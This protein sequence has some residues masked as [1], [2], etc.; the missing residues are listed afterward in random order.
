MKCENNTLLWL[1]NFYWFAILYDS[2]TD[3]MPAKLD[4]SSEQENPFC[5]FWS[6]VWCNKCDRDCL[7][8]RRFSVNLEGEN[9]PLTAKFL[10]YYTVP[11]SIIHGKLTQRALREIIV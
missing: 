7:L 10:I 3:L 4:T 1:I 5:S 8:S 6:L 9:T 11:L 2:R